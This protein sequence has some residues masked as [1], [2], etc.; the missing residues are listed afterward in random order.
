MTHP[1]RL[2]AGLA[3]AAGV[4]A[5]VAGCGG[6]GPV[7]AAGTVTLDG[8]PLPKAGLLFQPEDPAGRPGAAT[9]GPDGRFAVPADPGLMPGRYKV[10]VSVAD[11]A[12]AA[13]ADPVAVDINSP[14]YMEAMRKAQTAP[15]KPKKPTLPARY[16]SPKDTPLT[17]DVPAGGASNLTVPPDQFLTL[18]WGGV[19]S[20]PAPA[21]P[22]KPTPPPGTPRTAWPRRASRRRG[23]PTR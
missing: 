14:A 3:A 18:G 16:S 2:L 10:V 1:I 22:T 17:V 7:A 11:E 12:K 15:R 6:G 13:D 5:C 8:A 23:R 21:A 19:A 4:A 20:L 9:T